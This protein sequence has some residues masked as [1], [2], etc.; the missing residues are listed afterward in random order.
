MS[1]TTETGLRRFIGP[2][3]YQR[4]SFR[5][6]GLDVTV[7]ARAVRRRSG[8]AGTARSS[9]AGQPPLRQRSL[10]ERPVQLMRLPPRYEG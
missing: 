4:N 7:S 1:R 3:I 5:V 9:S 8:S 2:E 10:G 6:A